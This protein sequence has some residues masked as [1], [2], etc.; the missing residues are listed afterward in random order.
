MNWAKPNS[1]AA[2]RLAGRNPRRDSQDSGN[3]Q[4]ISGR[5]GG[6]PGAIRDEILRIQEIGR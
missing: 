5:R 2:R 3:R 6:L 4:V 1:E